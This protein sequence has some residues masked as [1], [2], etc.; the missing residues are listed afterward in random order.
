MTDLDPKD[1]RILQMV[2]SN[3]VCTLFEYCKLGL[4]MGLPD[5]VLTRNATKISRLEMLVLTRQLNRELEVSDFLCD[6]LN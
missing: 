5:D 6:F 1:L 3:N 2:E 4:L